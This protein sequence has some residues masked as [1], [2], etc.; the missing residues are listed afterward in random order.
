MDMKKLL[1]TLDSSSKK[2]AEGSSDMKKLLQVVTEGKNPKT[3][4]LS[5]A[6]NIVYMNTPK[7]K[8]VDLNETPSLFKTYLKLVEEEDINQE[9]NLRLKLSEHLSEVKSTPAPK[10]PN[11][12]A[13]HAMKTTSGAGAHTNKK[14]AEKQ[15]DVKHK[16]QAV[17][18]DENLL[19]MESQSVLEGSAH[20]YNVTKFY[21]KFRDQS[22]ITRWLKKE[23]GLPKETKLYFDDADLVLGSD[24]IV[25]YA[26]VDETLKFND[27]LTALVKVT[28]GTAKQKVDGVYRSQGVDENLSPPDGATAPPPKGKDGQYPIVTSGPHKGKRWSP[29]TPGPTNPAFKEGVAGPQ[30]CWPGHRKVGT[31]PGT[32]KNAGKRVNDCE[33]IKKESVKPKTTPVNEGDE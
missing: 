25:P 31:Q 30:H 2:A 7:P 32:G 5:Q 17:P 12:V 6:E 9:D 26:L 19:T 18:V 20:G 21:R 15:G 1:Q 4:R 29:Q 10:P 23:A 11:F 16:K 24:T 13:K 33:K 8:P 27:L 28:G 22:K 14:R 3:N